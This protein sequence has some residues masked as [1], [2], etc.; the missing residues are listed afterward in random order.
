MMGNELDEAL[1]AV[2]EHKQK[3]RADLRNRVLKCMRENPEM[4]LADIRRRFGIS[5]SLVKALISEPE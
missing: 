2:R 3:D 5:F 1:E 4:K